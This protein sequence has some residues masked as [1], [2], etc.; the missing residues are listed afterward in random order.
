[1]T[2][3]RPKDRFGLPKMTT[4]QEVAI[5]F[6]LFSLGTLLILS[7]LYPLSNMMEIGPAYMGVIMTATGYFFAI[8]SIRELEEKD[9]FLSKRL[10]K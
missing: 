4:N 10:M 7:V 5:S 3:E 8:E 1:M 6:A 2:E 9:H